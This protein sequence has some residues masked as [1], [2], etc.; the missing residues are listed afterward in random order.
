MAY[1]P[2]PH[3]EYFLSCDFEDLSV[4]DHGT[5][6]VPWPGYLVKVLAQSDVDLVTDCEVK[7]WNG[8]VAARTEDFTFTLD[9]S[10]LDGPGKV[11]E[12]DYDQ[13]VT[14]ANYIAEQLN[15]NPQ[16]TAAA[17]SQASLVLVIRRADGEA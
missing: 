14:N 10:I 11:Q 12:V 1:E 15:F 7:G 4:V 9:A 16:G 2:R 6:A 3:E 5:F 13:V 17:G 8:T